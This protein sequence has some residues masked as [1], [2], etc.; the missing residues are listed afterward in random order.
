MKAWRVI[1][2]AVVIFA[3]GMVTGGLAVHLKQ[4]KPAPQ[5]VSAGFSRQ[6]GEVL[7]RMQR[8][9][10]LSPEQRQKIEG[11]LRDSNARMNQLWDT[12]AP[13]ARE[14][15][16]RVNDLIRAELREDQREKFEQMLKSHRGSRSV[17]T[18][19]RIDER[20]DPKP[21]RKP[22]PAESP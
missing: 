22:A 10:Y 6:R 8:R 12:V 17:E 16:N 2:A 3:A 5:N 21:I 14:E 20:R 9:L 7:D 11:I 13:Q 18:K 4:T 15:H 19:R 1:L